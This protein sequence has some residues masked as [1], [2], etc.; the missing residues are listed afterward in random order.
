MDINDKL[1][2]NLSIKEFTG[3]MPSDYQLSF[4]K[5]IAGNIQKLRD[6]LNS[7]EASSWKTDIS[8]DIQISI[9]NGLRTIDDYNRLLAK[10]Y[11]PSKSSDHFFGLSPFFPKPS[12]GAADISLVNCK[13]DLW[14]VH[15]FIISLYK[16][17]VVKFGQ[18]IYEKGKN[19]PWIHLGNDWTD[20]FSSNITGNTRQRFLVSMDNG[21]TYQ[22]RKI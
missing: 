15:E 22:E 9:N 16:K 11:N 18:I 1:S 5:I 21:K 20:I 12:L 8:K 2:R 6:S 13:K 4:M 10:G 7:Q 3:S 19:N 14:E 17:G